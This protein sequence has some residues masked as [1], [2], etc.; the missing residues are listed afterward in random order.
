MNIIQ[1]NRIKLS[2]RLYPKININFLDSYI[3]SH[4][5]GTTSITF[6]NSLNILGVKTSSSVTCSCRFGNVE[7]LLIYLYC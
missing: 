2:A 6:Q 3:D 7:L 4:I 1:V 5:V